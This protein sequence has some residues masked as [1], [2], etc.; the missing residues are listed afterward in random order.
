MSRVVTLPEAEFLAFRKQASFVATGGIPRMCALYDLA[1]LGKALDTAWV[2]L[3]PEYGLGL[4]S[5]EGP[6][7]AR[8]TPT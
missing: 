2:E 1:R 8:A 3:Q 6:L 4:N 5:R 7:I